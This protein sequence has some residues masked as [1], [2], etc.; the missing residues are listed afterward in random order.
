MFISR[1]VTIRTTR[2][3]VRAEKQSKNASLS[4]ARNTQRIKDKIGFILLIKVNKREQRR[5]I[6]CGIFGRIML[7]RRG[8]VYE[9]TIRHQNQG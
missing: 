1:F 2:F 7:K 3:R 8:K 9:S 4:V 5:P 6:L